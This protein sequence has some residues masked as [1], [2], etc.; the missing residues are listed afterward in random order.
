MNFDGKRSGEGKTFNYS[1]LSRSK[2][3]EAKVQSS[4]KN[5]CPLLLHKNEK[6]AANNGQGGNLYY[7]KEKQISDSKQVLIEEIEIPLE[8]QNEQKAN[9]NKKTEKNILS[10]G[11]KKKVINSEKRKSSKSIQKKARP[12]EDK[13]YQKFSA[14]NNIVNYQ[15]NFKSE[16]TNKDTNLYEEDVDEK[17]RKQSDLIIKKGKVFNLGSGGDSKSISP[18]KHTSKQ[19]EENHSSSNVSF[20]KN[21][22]DLFQPHLDKEYNIP[23]SK[24]RKDENSNLDDYSNFLKQKELNA[25]DPRNFNPCS[26]SFKKKSR[27]EK[28][29]ENTSKR[30]KT[31]TH[32]DIEKKDM[33]I[34]LGKDSKNPNPDHQNSRNE[35]TVYS[36]NTGGPSIQRDDFANEF[37]NQ[38]RVK[39]YVQMSKGDLHAGSASS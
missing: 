18:M 37:I 2:S 32:I 21:K 6:E 35:F 13:V 39:D 15:A 28:L 31:P 30:H 19:S 34:M 20:S 12:S 17:K 23:I 8:E 22:K 4:S 11:K 27:N 14:E 7:G 1:V 25:S 38:V 29:R 36:S 24:G 9:E 3:G 26:V 33:R 10:T 16:R 5:D